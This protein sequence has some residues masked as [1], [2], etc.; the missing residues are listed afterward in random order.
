[1]LL[2]EVDGMWSRRRNR[3]AVWARELLMILGTERYGLKLKDLAREPPKVPQRDDEG[4]YMCRW[5]KGGGQRIPSRHQ[6]IG[7]PARRG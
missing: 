6:R 1:M 2:V 5:K 4:H 7:P 3:E